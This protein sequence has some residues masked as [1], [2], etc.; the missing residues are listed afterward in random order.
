MDS[1]QEVEERVNAAITA[2][3]RVHTQ[4]LTLDEA[5][6]IKG[7]VYLNNEVCMNG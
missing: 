4:I 1:A 3:H 5:Q 7:I 2:G 6:K